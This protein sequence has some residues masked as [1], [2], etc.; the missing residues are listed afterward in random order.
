MIHPN[1]P[2]CADLPRQRAVFIAT[3]QNSEPVYWFGGGYDLTPY[4]GFEEDCVHWHR[5][6]RD[7]C[8]PFGEGTYKRFKTGAM[9]TFI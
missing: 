1:N 5:T 8:E 7:A 9:I 4:Y 6:A 2:L 3:P